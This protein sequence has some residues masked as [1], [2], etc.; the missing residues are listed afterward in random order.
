MGSKEKI[1]R[2]EAIDSRL[3]GCHFENANAV[4]QSGECNQEVPNS[5]EAQTQ[6]PSQN[7]CTSLDKEEALE[8]AW[9]ALEHLHLRKLETEERQLTTGDQQSMEVIARIG[10][11]CKDIEKR[12]EEHEALQEAEA[13]EVLV[14]QPVSIGRGKEEPTTVERGLEEGVRLFERLWCDQ[15]NWDKGVRRASGAV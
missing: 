1:P 9:A 15:A 4:Q 7:Q 13:E 10:E 2:E 12:I 6:R 11:Q 5:W 8:N 14:N 3:R